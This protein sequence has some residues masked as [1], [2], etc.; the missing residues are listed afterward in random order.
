MK[1]DRL[2]TDTHYPR[3]ASRAS[4]LTSDHGYAGSFD[5]HTIRI[6]NDGGSEGDGQLEYEIRAWGPCVRGGEH[7]LYQPWRQ[8]YVDVLAPRE[9]SIA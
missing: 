4:T 9:F 5:V 7:G 2:A 1:E 3:Y 8:N 6:S